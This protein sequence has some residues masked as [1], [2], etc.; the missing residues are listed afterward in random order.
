MPFGYVGIGWFEELDQFAGPEEV[1]NVEQSRFRGASFSFA[2]KSFDPPATA[3][4]WANQYVREPKPGKLV[5]HST[6]LTTPKDWIG[7]RFLG[8]ADHLKATNDT[9]YRHEYLGEVV[10]SGTQ[11][12]DNIKLKGRKES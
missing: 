12:F 8:D 3:R 6:Y 4:S 10:G 9:A 5:H 2:F 1:R 7:P 11:V